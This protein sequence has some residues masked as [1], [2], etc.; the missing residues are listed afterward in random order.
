M[1]AGTGTTILNYCYS[2]LVIAEKSTS[3]MWSM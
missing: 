2:L 3:D 1:T